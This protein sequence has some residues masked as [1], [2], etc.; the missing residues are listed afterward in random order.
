MSTTSNKT[1]GPVVPD[2]QYPP[3]AVVT[4][5]DHA[6]WIIIAAA[7]GMFCSLFF[8]AIRFGVRKFVAPKFGLDDYTLAGATLLMVIQTAII[9]GACTNGLGKAVDL[10]SLAAQER[11]QSMYYVSNLFFILALGLSKVSVGFFLKR[12][13]RAKHHNLVYNIGMGLIG[14]WT[15]ASFL[16]LALQCN[17]GQPWTIVGESCGTGVVSS[18]VSNTFRYFLTEMQ[19]R[20]WQVIAA[21][22]ILSEVM[23]VG[24]AVYLVW[25]LQTSWEAKAV[26]ICVFAFRLV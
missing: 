1:Y 14:A 3:F 17:L 5:D 24:M 18:I 25:A 4:P 26:V 2:G 13:S 12:L 8:G 21:F 20:R 19:L 6:A 10:L 15:F 23:L 16:A 9:L 11:V 7:V 22:D